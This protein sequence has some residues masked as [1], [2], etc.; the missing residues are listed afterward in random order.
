MK[1]WVGKSAGQHFELLPWQ[2][3]FFAVLMGLKWKADGKRV[4]RNV[5]LQCSRKQGK[6]SIIAALALYHLIADG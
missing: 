1:H 3:F 2:Q 5:Y 4:V 6:S